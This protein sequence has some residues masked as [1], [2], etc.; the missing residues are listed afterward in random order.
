MRGGFV[1]LSKASR[2]LK[3]KPCPFNASRRRRISYI[4]EILRLKPQDDRGKG[5]KG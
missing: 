3:A 1:I 5:V 4:K 2:G